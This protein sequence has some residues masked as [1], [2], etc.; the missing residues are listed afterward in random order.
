MPSTS[1]PAVD[2]SAAARTSPPMGTPWAGTV[3]VCPSTTVATMG[4]GPYERQRP[5][6][7]AVDEEHPAHLPRDVDAPE[8]AA[9]V[10][11]RRSDVL[12]LALAELVA[13]LRDH[14]FVEIERLVEPPQVLEAH[15]GVGRVGH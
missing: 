7:P 11:H 6:A 1:M 5:A 4:A 8:R 2:G 13:E 9:Q 15:G 12:L 10:A 3:T 14:L